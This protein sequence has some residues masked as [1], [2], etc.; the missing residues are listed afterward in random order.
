[1]E[2]ELTEL[3][4]KLNELY[5]PEQV[6]DYCPNGLQIEGRASV[7]RIITGVSASM[8]LFR[9]AVDRKA[10]AILV[11]HGIFWKSTPQ[12]LHGSHRDRIR[13]LLENDISLIAY[14]LPMDLHPELGNN[15][16][17]VKILGLENPVPFGQYGNRKIGFSGSLE[18][19]M[20][21]GEFLDMIRTRIHPDAK[22]L[23]R[24]PEQI[25]RIAVVSGGAADVFQQAIDE[26]MDLYLTGEPAE[27]AFHV[28]NE[29]GVYFLAAGHHATER[30]GPA[31]IADW[32][33]SRLG[34]EA[35]FVDLW[36]P[37]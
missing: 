17:L 8:D 12:V 10:D 32:L 24:G 20:N 22:I 27:W 31:A 1:M 29:S 26:R 14:H 16:G 19:P 23:G 21:Q 15:A 18:L 34:L 25:Q 30:P 11:H 33:R 35:E 5:E 6:S 13:I 7:N 36:N 37:V 4:R 3:I 2:M 28:A 9:E